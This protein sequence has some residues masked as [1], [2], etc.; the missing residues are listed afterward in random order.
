[1]PRPDRAPILDPLRVMPH[2]VG[3]DHVGA[4]VLAD[5][6][7]ASVDVVGNARQH[8]RGRVA[9]RL[10]PGRADQL[11]VGADPARGDDHGRRPER[12]LAHRGARA[13]LPA[14]DGARLEHGPC[15]SVQRPAVGGEAV[16][17]VAEFQRDVPAGDPVAHPPLEGL[18]QPGTGTPGDVEARH[19]VA[20]A[21]GQIPAA[22]G[23]PRGREEAH[24]LVVQPLALLARGEL[25]VR[26]GPLAGPAVLG[27]VEAGAAQ[28]VLER[29]L[30]GV[31]DAGPALLG[32][33]HEEQAAE[34]PEGLAAERR[35]GLLVEQDHAPAGVGQLGR[36]DEAGQ[37]TA[38]DDHVRVEGHE[39]ICSSL[40]SSG[41]LSS[42]QRRILVPWR[43]RPP[44]AWSKVTSTTSSGRSEIHSSSR[45]AL[46]AAGVAVAAL[47][48]F[49]RRQLG[50]QRTL[51]GGLQPG[52]VADDVQ[53]AG[54]VVEAEDQRSDRVG[55]L[56]GAPAG[57]D[58]VDRPHALDLGHAGALAGP[59]GR[60]EVLGHHTL[61]AAQPR[62]GLVGVGRERRAVDPA[63]EHS[64]S[65]RARRSA[66]GFSSH[67]SSPMASRSNA[68]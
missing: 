41:A 58:G 36:G 13:R 27:A 29:E 33:V 65:S 55:L 37:P 62:L 43:I 57:H 50:D 67:D 24:P 3:V 6:D 54:V 11:V 25:D 46:P 32:A 18:D 22:L 60:A 4:G 53:P 16:G 9:E 44:L 47:T 2:P 5:P 31:L 42:R 12:E 15:H 10:R 28:P 45:L 14:G 8:P 51:L 63:V 59:V 40:Q 68:T 23:P 26:L 61:A 39:D 35:L 52:G 19:R 66:N 20:V 17:A 64:A 1:M 34:R 7:H 56:A 49:V 38:D 30:G 21:G 48:G